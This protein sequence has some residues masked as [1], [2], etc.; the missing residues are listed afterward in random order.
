MRPIVPEPGKVDSANEIA[1][2]ALERRLVDWN[3]RTRC[4]YHTIQKPDKIQ[5]LESRILAKTRKR[6]SPLRNE[7]TASAATKIGKIAA[8]TAD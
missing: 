1:S 6:F 2:N 7:A 5:E 8:T 3:N 4:Q